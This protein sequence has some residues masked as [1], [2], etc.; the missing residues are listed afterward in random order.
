MELDGLTASRFGGRGI[1]ER[2]ISVRAE[3][4]KATQCLPTNPRHYFRV[5]TRT[6]VSVISERIGLLKT[7]TLVKSDD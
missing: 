7:V 1:V 6:L 3:T 5:L 2:V 4:K